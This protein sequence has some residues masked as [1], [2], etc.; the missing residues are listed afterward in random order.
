MQ[1]RL[2]CGD[3][4]VQPLLL[5]LGE[6][7]LGVL[8]GCHLGRCLEAAPHGCRLRL[9]RCLAAASL[10]ELQPEMMVLG[11]H[12]LLGTGLTPDWHSFHLEEMTGRSLW[13]GSS[14]VSL[15]SRRPLAAAIPRR[16]P[17]PLPPAAGTLKHQL[18]SG[19]VAGALFLKV[20][21]GSDW[22]LA[23]HPS[24]ILVKPPL[25]RR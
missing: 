7:Q 16:Q 1:A 2:P 19:A 15:P 22:R 21:F 12:S 10:G 17:A 4:L 3:S 24:A 11:C 6:L 8:H 25:S 14:V 5:S 18:S 9:V 23:G 13:L 20:S